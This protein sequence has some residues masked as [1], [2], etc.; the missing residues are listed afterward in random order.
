MMDKLAPL[1]GAWT[2]EAV[3]PASGP[4]GPGGRCTFEYTL[5]G[6]YLLQRTTIDHPAAPDALSIIA[7]DGENYLQHYFD[8]RGVTRLYRMTFDGTTWTLQRDEPDFSELSFTQRYEG[9]VAGDTITGR[10]MT[11]DEGGGWKLDFDLIYRKVDGDRGAR[12]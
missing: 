6:R 3:F 8:S 10:W 12:V 1:L 5:D 7:P 11:G 2:V 9:T 4:T